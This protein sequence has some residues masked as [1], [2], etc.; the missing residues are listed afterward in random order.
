MTAHK[1]PAALARE[2]AVEVGGDPRT[3]VRTANGAVPKGMALQHR[4][5]FSFERRGLGHLVAHLPPS[6]IL[7]IVGVGMP[8]QK[9]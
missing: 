5:K 9:P 4:L 6:P 1:L 3:V 8:E 2:I 7:L